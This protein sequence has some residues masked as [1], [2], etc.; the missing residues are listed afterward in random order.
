M[1]YFD[2][3]AP[4]S[5]GCCSDNR[6][7][8]PGTAIPRGSGY[9]FVSEEH[10]AF[11]QDARTISEVESKLNRRL[12]EAGASERAVVIY[13]PSAILCCVE[14]AR[15]R[16][17]DLRVAADDAIHWWE[18]GK[19]PLRPTPRSSP[20]A[21]R[22]SEG[23]K[24]SKQFLA[25]VNGFARAYRLSPDPYWKAL[26]PG[27]ARNAADE[28]SDFLSAQLAGSATEA[29]DIL[30]QLSASE[31]AEVSA[32]AKALL[33]KMKKDAAEYQRAIL[34]KEAQEAPQEHRW[35][36]FWK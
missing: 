17:L 29:L 19:V 2:E 31:F 10:V 6:C 21:A 35:W 4:S 25:T 33:A 14:A 32:A 3:P 23:D 7:P 34:D 24:P 9:L 12:S 18:T 27:T 22:H 28:S 8:C 5:D 26:F 13:E 15:R 36:Q 1:E 30:E 16:G 20:Q 11:R